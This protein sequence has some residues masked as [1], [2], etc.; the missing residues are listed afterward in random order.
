MAQEVTGM[1]AVL[2][3]LLLS[4]NLTTTMWNFISAPFRILYLATETSVGIRNMCRNI[5][6][7]RAPPTTLAIC[8]RC[9]RPCPFLYAVKMKYMIAALTTPHRSCDANQFTAYHALIFFCC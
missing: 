5:L 2:A 8:L 9:W 7:G 1:W 3:R 4:T 6:T